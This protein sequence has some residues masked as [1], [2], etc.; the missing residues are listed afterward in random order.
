MEALREKMNLSERRYHDIRMAMK[1]V[2]MDVQFMQFLERHDLIGRI[3]L[4][5]D[6]E[7]TLETPYYKVKD[8]GH[9]T[10]V[11]YDTN[12]TVYIM[13]S[14]SVRLNLR[15]TYGEQARPLRLLQPCDGEALSE[16]LAPEKTVSTKVMSYGPTLVCALHVHV[17]RLE[18]PSLSHEY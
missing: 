8:R 15:P 16:G 1:E 7:D 3:G 9:V 6:G 18:T 11:K 10:E 17:P 13:L 14:G 4:N 5:D 2:H 12:D